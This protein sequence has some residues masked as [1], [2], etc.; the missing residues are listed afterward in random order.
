ML[1]EIFASETVAD[2][3]TTF[4]VNSRKS[5]YLR[6]LSQLTGKYPQSISQAL[7]KLEKAG[8]VVAKKTGQQKF[9]QLDKGNPIYFELKSIVF[10]TNGIG[11]VIRD[12]L[13]RLKGLKMAFIY[14]PVGQTAPQIDLCLI[15]S[16]NLSKANDLVAKLE[17]KLG[18]GINL[19]VF[20]GDEWQK[21]KERRDH[22]VTEIL[23]TK[24]TML[25]GEEGEL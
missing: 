4:F 12:S 3:L 1:N 19:M 7:A 23:R 21:R 14:E 20:T 15:G 5:F 9:Y 13:K 8:V 24:K 2:L 16:V 10:K 6:E 22:F 18:R 25:M 11:R 17:K